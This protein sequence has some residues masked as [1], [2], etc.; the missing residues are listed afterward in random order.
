MNRLG[1]QQPIQDAF[2]VLTLA[3][4]DGAAGSGGSVSLSGVLQNKIY[5]WHADG[6]TLGVYDLD[7]AGLQG[8]IAAAVSGDTI[9]FPSVTIALTV[10]LTLTT[11]VLLRGLGENSILS[12]SGFSGAALTLEANCSLANFT[13]NFVSNG[14]TATGIQ[15][16]DN[17][18]SVHV[19][20]NVSGGSASNIAY[21]VTNAHTAYEAWTYTQ[22]T[23]SGSRGVLFSMD[24]FGGGSPTWYLI[25]MPADANAAFIDAHTNLTNEVH[26]LISQDGS[27]L[28]L[29]GRNTIGNVCIWKLD[30]IDAIRAAPAT[31]P[32]WTLISED[33][34][35]VVSSRRFQLTK[36]M[37]I[38][39]SNL[40]VNA[41]MRQSDG[42]LPAELD[43]LVYDG[44]A[45]TRETIPA[46]GDTGDNV[47]QDFIE[48]NNVFNQY[49]PKRVSTGIVT[50]A[51]LLSQKGRYW[52][53]TDYYGAI[54]QPFLS[55]TTKIRER[56]SGVNVH[57]FGADIGFSLSFS[58][59]W[60][61]PQVY[62]VRTSNGNAY[63]SDD[64]VTFS[65]LA[66]WAGGY[67]HDTKLAGDGSLAWLVATVLASGTHMRLY[68]RGGGVTQDLTGNLWSVVTNNRNF[69]NLGLVYT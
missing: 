58:G 30:N 36:G 47:N 14:T 34:V 18:V 57:D 63:L 1:R 50:E 42:S 2:R 21:G 23:V 15:L 64:G 25:A 29:R 6:S 62:T 31:A 53:Q 52:K 11:G 39:G 24:V 51:T 17:N 13:L 46:P 12:F 33:N 44:A 28:V 61:G 45:W 38:N 54:Y 32:T 10:A 60:Q 3:L 26:M 4:D 35:T 40:Y 56:I 27:L 55:T 37:I 16:A 65:L 68:D 19:N 66:T 48:T 43:Y 67:L 69:Y 59:A 22:P 9:I 5:V 8:A 49:V 7:E 20:V 41:T